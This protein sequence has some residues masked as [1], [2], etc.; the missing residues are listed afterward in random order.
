MREPASSKSSSA[1]HEKQ[2]KALLQLLADD[3]PW[4]FQ[5]VRR[6]LFALGDSVTTWLRP[7][8]LSDDPVLRRHAR[9]I[10]S[11]FGRQE[12]DTAFL[13][14]CVTQ[15]EDFDLE[16][17]LWL[18]AATCFDGINASGYRALLDSYASDLRE[19][20]NPAAPAEDILAACNHFLFDRLGFRGNEEHQHDPESAYLNRVIDRRTGSPVSLCSLYLLIAKRLR[21]PVTGIS[22]PGHFLLRF[23][24]AREEIYVDAFHRGKLL[25]K[26]DCLRYLAQTQHAPHEGQVAPVSPRRIVLRL[27]A[28]LHQIY[29]QRPDSVE[30]PRVQRYVIALAK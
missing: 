6:K 22:L 19:Q 14:F 30:A 24:N 13:T 7:H 5:E 3:D 26:I 21:L 11:Y 12:K 1:L 8:L 28:A 29:T 20:I 25:T 18:L 16:Q 23:Q 15:G 4:V 17:A 2:C 9:E 10:I 27:C